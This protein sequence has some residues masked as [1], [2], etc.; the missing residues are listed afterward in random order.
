MGASTWSTILL[1]ALTIVNAQS[2]YMY[3]AN[4]TGGL[5]ST[6]GQI[7]ASPTAA[8]ATINGTA[9]TYSVQFT[10]PASADIGP[11]VL[12]NIKDP[13]AKQAQTL[14]PGY[15]ASNVK[16]TENG[17]TATLNLAGS[18]CNVYGTDI[19]TLALEVDVQ[20]AHRLR[21]SIQPAYLDS[22]NMSQYILP[23]DLVHLPEQG[24]VQSDT[25]DVDL[26]FTWSNEPS[27]SFTVLRK[28]TGDVLFDTR[29]SVLVYENQFIEFVSQLPQDYNL[30]GMGEQ[31]HN[32]RLGN[33]YTTT[34]FAAD[35]G[36]PIDG[37]IYGVHP[38]YL[39]T[40]YFEVDA[41]TGERSLVSTSNATANGT[42][43]SASHGV[44][45]RNSHAM[46][47]LLL[48]TNVT[49][50]ALGGS[51][52][53]YVFDGPTQEAVTKQY[54]LG[55]HQ[56]RWGYKNWSEVEAVVNSY[57]AFNI[58]LENI[59]T[60]IDYMFQYRDF[61]NDQNTFPYPEGQAFLERLHANG[62]HYVPIVDSAIY[63]PN[64]NNASDA[65]APY[66]DGNSSGVFLKNPDGSQYIGEVWPGYTVFPDWHATNSVAWWTRN[67]QSHH[68]NVPWDGIWIDMSEVSSFCVG[69]CGTGNLSLNPVH[70]GF[71]LPGEPGSVVYGY[72][73]GFNLT[74]ATEAATATSLAA[75]QASSAA[76]ASPPSTATTPYFSSSVTPGVRNVNQP[77]YVINNVNGDLAVHAV[78]PNATHA[79]GVEEYDVHN[80]F[81]H[82]ILNAT[83]QALLEIFPGKRPFI[84]GRSTFAGT[85]KWAGHWGGDN[86]SLFAY[87][88]FSI[89]QALSFS[90]FVRISSFIPPLRPRFTLDKSQRVD[91]CGFN[92]NSDEELCNRWMQLSAFFPFYR[93]HNV[94]SA[95]SQE[96]YVWASVAEAS[97]TAMA[98]RY[99][100][101]PYMY[102]L[103]YYASTTGSTVMRALAW[104]FPNDPTLAAIDNQ[105]LLGPAI[106]VTP[107]LGQGL[108]SAQGVFP[109]IAQGEVWYDWYTQ[110]AV[111]AQPGENVTIPA[112]LGHI[113]VFIRGGYV[114]PQ[115]EPLYTTA[116]SRNSSWSLLVALS[117][118]GAASGQVYVDD[119]ASLVPSATLLVDL[120][121]S[122]GSLWASARGTYEDTNALAN[123]TVMGVATKPST[124][125]LN[126]QTVSNGVSYNGS[127]LSVKGLEAATS[128]GAWAQ[129]W[130]LSWE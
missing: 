15:T 86:T 1:T 99:S 50:R 19:E 128:K 27:F 58:P 59:W 123:V 102:T 7:T 44:Y 117:K 68:N 36:D 13:S 56:C 6:S 17:L 31:I 112:P 49:W 32:L 72:P 38:T 78:S 127:V 9:T 10:V 90:L 39:E 8:T 34:F 93:N 20:S 126:G 87:M 111:V 122:N 25:Q 21:I 67:M 51:I 53:L 105:F 66:N 125:T 26:L 83:Y 48:P 91:T 14:C 120:T 92:G 96:A 29:G 30:Y 46:E 79:D 115:Q 124:V 45:M 35:A 75:V 12:P 114:L 70:P 60:D 80:L 52:D 62:Q 2:T 110:Q 11:N 73:E 103:F 65:Y 43:E 100:L 109:G 57:R 71:G 33:N 118:D 89:S 94:L 24:V 121:A 97:R 106:L 82:Q 113:P 130:V 119:G 3:P 95:N 81:G 18:A 23:D 74:N 107:V 108:T 76:A 84:I 22:S 64:P 47:A 61:T 77:P 88:Y 28:S 63:I 37:N 85:G 16:R 40:R 4:G 55:F 129:D 42:Y 54:Q 101:L 116:E 5:S 69:S 98:I 104:E 41:K